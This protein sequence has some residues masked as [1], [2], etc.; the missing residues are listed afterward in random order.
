[1]RGSIILVTKKIQASMTK[2]HV[3]WILSLDGAS[4]VA[5]A[6]REELVN[7]ILKPC[8]RLSVYSGD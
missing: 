3:S 5:L 1:M 6:I 4:E 8:L 2:S 7:V